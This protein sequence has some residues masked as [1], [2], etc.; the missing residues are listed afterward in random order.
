MHGQ[1]Q[2]G[3]KES[4]WPKTAPPYKLQNASHS[5][6]ASCWFSS[7]ELSLKYLKSVKI[8]VAIKRI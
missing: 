1:R 5:C 8:A 4:S 7:F 3:L 2:L 6:A